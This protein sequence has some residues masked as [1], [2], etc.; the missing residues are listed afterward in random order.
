M[1]R[2]YGLGPKGMGEKTNTYIVILG[3]AV[4]QMKLED[5]AR[6]KELLTNDDYYKIPTRLFPAKYQ[7]LLDMAKTARDR[8]LIAFEAIETDADPKFILEMYREKSGVF[9]PDVA[10]RQSLN[11]TRGPPMQSSIRKTVTSFGFGSSRVV[12]KPLKKSSPKRSKKPK[13]KTT[14]FV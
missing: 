13:R 9:D 2:F 14:L 8:Q 6:I 3:N 12:A 5:V 1:F 7:R 10:Y 11:L 4:N